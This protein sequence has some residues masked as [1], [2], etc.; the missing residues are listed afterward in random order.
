MRAVLLILAFLLSGVL[1]HDR[2]DAGVTETKRQPVSSG[3][4]TAQYPV[5]AGLH[6][7]GDSLGGN[8][9]ESPSQVNQK[10]HH[11]FCALSLRQLRHFPHWLYGYLNHFSA[12]CIG[13]SVR[14]I[15]FPFHYFW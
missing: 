10:D 15:I 13:L 14:Q 5:S 1:A 12:I 11:S 6:K 3:W 9:A 4:I 8:P 2:G 7:T